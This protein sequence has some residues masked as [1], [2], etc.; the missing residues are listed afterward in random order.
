M[1]D[2]EAFTGWQHWKENSPADRGRSVQWRTSTL[3]FVLTSQ[4]FDRAEPSRAEP[5]AAYIGTFVIAIVDKTAWYWITLIVSSGVSE[6]M[7]KQ[8]GWLLAYWLVFSNTSVLHLH[9]FKRALLDAVKFLGK[10]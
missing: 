5:R 9:Y 3:P 1:Y 10:L 7:G 6:T 8:G 2:E 4:S